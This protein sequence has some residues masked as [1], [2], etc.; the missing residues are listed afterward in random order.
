MSLKSSKIV[1]R[2]K[3]YVP[4]LIFVLL[5]NVDSSLFKDK[6]TRNIFI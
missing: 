5:K 4:A 3:T 6:I 1:S 2:T